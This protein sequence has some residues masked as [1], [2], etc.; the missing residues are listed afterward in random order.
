MCSDLKE[1]IRGLQLRYDIQLLAPSEDQKLLLE[2]WKDHVLEDALR[3]AWK[4][5]LSTE[6]FKGFI[7]HTH[8]AHAGQVISMTIIV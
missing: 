6:K 5:V 3:H 7:L 2:F 8:C 4:K 1:T